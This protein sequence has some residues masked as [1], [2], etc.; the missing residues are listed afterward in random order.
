MSWPGVERDTV[1]LSLALALYCTGGGAASWVDLFV[2][3]S[4]LRQSHHLALHILLCES[5]ARGSINNQI[6]VANEI[7]DLL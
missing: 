6:L 1:D 4:A 2:A 3:A 7:I 5:E